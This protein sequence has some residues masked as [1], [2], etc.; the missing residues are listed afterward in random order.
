MPYFDID[1]EE[2][3]IKEFQKRVFWSQSDLSMKKTPKSVIYS[4]FFEPF[5]IT[6][7][8]KFGRIFHSYLLEP[9]KF[10]DEYFCFSD[11]KK[12]EELIKG[13]AKSPR[14]TKDY[15]EWKKELFD[16]N[17]AIDVDTEEDWHKSRKQKMKVMCNTD[18]LDAVK[19]M[20]K[21]M[22]ENMPL[23]T[24]M[25]LEHGIVE[26]KYSALILF[27]SDSLNVDIF[28]YDEDAHAQFLKEKKRFLLIR[29]KPDYI[30]DTFEYLADYK[31]ADKGGANQEEFERNAYKYD[32]H[33]QVAM[34]LDIISAH[35]GQDI[36]QFFYLVC[37][38]VPPYE[39]NYFQVSQEV[40]E[41]G[42]RVYRIRLRKLLEDFEKRRFESYGGTYA[43]NQHKL[44]EMR[45]PKWYN[46]QPKF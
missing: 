20:K 22:E 25:S 19:E 7:A 21:S 42:K 6:E 34:E 16:S 26:K 13:G 31:S 46:D 44:L 29:T 14:S 33:I 8:F 1:T 39:C 40:I 15:K 24:L 18:T 11:A 12:I 27:T 23:S 4:K 37:E 45:L 17:N 32:H 28:P 9:E 3:I 41:Y 38:K 35:C 2:K 30:R 36:D 5:T 10:Q 43:E